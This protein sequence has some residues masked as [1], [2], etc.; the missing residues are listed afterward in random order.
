VFVER[1]EFVSIGGSIED[2]YKQH[3]DAFPDCTTAIAR[4]W[5]KG[6]TVVFEYAEGGTNTGP[7]RSNKPTGKKVGFVGAS[8]LTFSPKGIIKK[9]VTFYDQLTMEIQAGWAPALLA[10]LEVR[11]V[12][13]VPPATGS[14]EVHQVNGVDVG[15]PRLFAIRKNLYSSFS[16]RSEKD[17]LASLSDDIIFAPFD[18]P[19]NATGKREAGALFS[20]WMKTF[21]YGV[22]NADEAW[23]VDGHI[24]LLGTYTGKHVGAWGPLKATN[25][26]FKS[27]FL[28]IARINKDDKIERVWTY[29]NNFEILRDLGFR[30]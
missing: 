17:F 15:Q 26:P 28:D 18:D 23:S 9:D 11:P 6:D 21:S 20:S 3:F 22:V 19:K 30:G 1:G 2:T 4:S 5:H 29:A 27:H 7:H 14:W 25:K 13:A 10:K 24:L 12:I 8:V 16:M